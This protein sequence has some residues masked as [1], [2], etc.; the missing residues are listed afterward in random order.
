MEMTAD[1]YDILQ[2]KQLRLY[3]LWSKFEHKLSLHL[4]FKILHKLCDHSNT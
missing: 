2:E 4:R 3:I 1:D